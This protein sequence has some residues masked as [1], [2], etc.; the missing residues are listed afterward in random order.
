M[1]KFCDFI[2]KIYKAFFYISAF[3][4]AAMFAVCAYSV[5]SRFIGAPSKWADELIRFLMRGL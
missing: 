1:Q 3:F 4:L 5:F 2:D